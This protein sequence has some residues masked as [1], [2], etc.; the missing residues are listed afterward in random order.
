QIQNRRRVCSLYEWLDNG[1]PE[2]GGFVGKAPGCR[3]V[4][5]YAAAV[6]DGAGLERPLS[7]GGGSGSSLVKRGSRGHPHPAARSA[8]RG[9]PGLRHNYSLPPKIVVYKPQPRAACHKLLFSFRLLGTQPGVAMVRR[10]VVV[11]GEEIFSPVAVEVAPD[12]VDVVGVV[13]RVVEL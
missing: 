13:L 10:V 2:G 8:R 5:G 4:C 7:H 12:A 1:R 9:P 11:L 6:V 3:V